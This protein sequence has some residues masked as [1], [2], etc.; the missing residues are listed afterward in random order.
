MEALPDSPSSLPLTLLAN[1][2]YVGAREA[3]TFF[4]LPGTP[5]QVSAL[6]VSHGGEDEALFGYYAIVLNDA[7]GLVKV[8]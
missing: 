6:D 5:I 7:R 1:D 4:E 2:V 8:S 3:V